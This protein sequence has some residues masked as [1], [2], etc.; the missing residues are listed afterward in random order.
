MQWNNFNN[1]VPPFNTQKKGA[2][3]YKYV[4]ELH[5][6]F[7]D[8]WV[9]DSLVFSE[10]RCHNDTTSL[11]IQNLNW[12]DF[13][14]NHIYDEKKLCKKFERICFNESDPSMSRFPNKIF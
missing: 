5:N 2:M 3:T 14:T 6:S 1:F 12:S 11:I 4:V 13:Q 10:T 9:T 8:S 7:I